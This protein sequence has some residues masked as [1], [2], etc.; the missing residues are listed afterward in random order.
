[1]KEFSQIVDFLISNKIEAVF[2]FNNLLYDENYIKSKNIRVFG[3]EF[4]D[5]HFP[6]DTLIKTFLKNVFQL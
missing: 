5:G 2:R 4:K 3:M 1:M 6:P